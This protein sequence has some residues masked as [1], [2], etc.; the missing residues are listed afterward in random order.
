[1]RATV[2]GVRSS[3]EAS[4]TN[5]RSRSRSRR[6]SAETR[7]ASSIA[8]S[9]RCAC[10]IMATNIAAMSGTSAISSTGCAP[11]ATSTAISRPVETMTTA[12]VRNVGRTRQTRKPY[13]NV[14]LTQMKWNG[15]VSH[16]G[17][18][19]M[20]T[21]FATPNAAHATSTQYRRHG[22]RAR[23]GIDPVP[24]PT[25][26]DDHVRAEL[27]AQSPHV[28]VHDVRAGVEVISPD[29]GQQ[30][31]LRHRR[32]RVS[33]Q[34]LEQE[35]L[36]LRERHRPT[37]RVDLAT[38]QIHHDPARPDRR[39]AGASDPPK[40]GA[41]PRQELVER[42]GLGE[43]VLRAELQAGDL[44]GRVRQGRQDEDRL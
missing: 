24:D 34:L 7:L 40:S 27:G 6:F 1:P 43:V 4:C 16:S 29:G 35:E 33:Q 31:L 17:S 12:S 2:M 11:R 32:S 28:H 13:S 9:L 20:A 25:F 38:E 10:H 36:P 3:W 37:P 18:S 39:G 23:S 41:D 21:R 44:R 14:R 42:E 8:T 30:P 15:T 26:G 22:H 19:S 5:R